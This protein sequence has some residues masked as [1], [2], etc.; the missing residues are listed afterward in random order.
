MPSRAQFTK[1]QRNFLALEYHK[2][3]DAR[4]FIPGLI[5]DFIRKFPGTRPPSKNVPRKIWEKQMNKGTVNNCNSKA[6]PGP[7]NSGPRVTVTTVANQNAVRRLLQRDQVKRHGDGNVSPVRSSRKNGMG[8]TKSSWNRLTKM[9]KFHPYRM[10]RRQQLL[11]ADM[12]RR[13]RFSQWILNRT[14]NQL[15][16]LLFSDEANF[17]LSGHVNSYNIRRYS[18][19][20]VYDP[21]SGGRPDHFVHE[22]PTFSAKL[23]VFCGLKQ[24]GTF[25]LKFYRNVS[26]DGPMYH[27]LLQYHVLP[28][29]RT[30]N[31]G[32]LNNLWWTQDGAPCHVTN[33]NMQYLDSQFQDRVVSRKAVRG[34]DWPA[35]SPDLNP[36]DF[37]LWGYLKSKVYT[38]RPQTLDQLERNITREV[39]SIPPVMITRAI[40]DIKERAS[41]C[42]RNNGGHFE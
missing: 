18:Q 22:K 42:L 35:R 24:D 12:P 32:N 41:K 16:R 28:E 15:K 10:V 30:S 11:A 36:C 20:K 39:Q 4:G 13:L 21:V 27:S 8:L 1:D 23:M 17:E 5:A 31:N 19:T 6:S 14:D 9:M 40:L 2:R 38:P 7:N 29:L 33:H 25:G 34:E 3:K 37:F 26:M